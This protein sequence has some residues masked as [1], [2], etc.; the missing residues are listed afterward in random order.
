[1][2]SV[3]DCA[4]KRRTVA[5]RNEWYWTGTMTTP[6][7]GKRI[8]FVIGAFIV[9]SLWKWFNLGGE[10]HSSPRSL[11]DSKVDCVLTHSLN[12][13]RKEEKGKGRGGGWYWVQ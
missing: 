7:I 8:G 5:I 1:M 2:S 3:R 11:E 6:S 9:Y 13:E 12:I 10:S 4:M